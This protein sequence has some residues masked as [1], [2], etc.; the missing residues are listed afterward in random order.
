MRGG[1]GEEEYK[2]SVAIG[3]RGGGFSPV[4]YQQGRF[5]GLYSSSFEQVSWTLWEILIATVPG[6]GPGVSG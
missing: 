2:S 5:V 3:M 4:G 1:P 6:C